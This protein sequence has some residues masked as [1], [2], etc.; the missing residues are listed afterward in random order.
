MVAVCGGIVINDWPDQAI[1]PA[2]NGTHG[3]V[4]FFCGK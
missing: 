4:S 3:D 1:H 2:E